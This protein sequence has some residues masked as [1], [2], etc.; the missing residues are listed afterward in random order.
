M[1]MSKTKHFLIAGGAGFIGTNLTLKL[2]E[3][4]HRVTVIDNFIT[5]KK[6]NLASVKN[7]PSFSLLEHDIIKPLPK[8]KGDIDVIFNLASPASPPAYQKY[9]LETMKVNSL[10][11]ENLLELAKQKNSR[12]VQASTSEVYGDPL[13]HPQKED[14]WGHTN[15][16]GPRSMYDEGKRYA[17]ALIW[18]YRQRYNVNTGIIR[19]F[20]TYGPFMDPQDGRVVTNFLTQ[21][22][23]NKPLTMYGDG[24]QTRSFCYIDDQVAAWLKMANVDLEGPVNIGNPQEITMAELVNIIGKILNKKLEITQESL[25]VDDPNKRCPNIALSKKELNWEPKVDL[26]TGLKNTIGWIKKQI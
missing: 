11:T 22:L 1:G 16:Y 21:A 9:S 10:G 7:H 24:K 17:E 20:N 6:E 8:I 5:G 14:Y 2:L 3:L 15:S 26:Q 19:I 23:K 18:S 25:P 13:V 12:F 4:G